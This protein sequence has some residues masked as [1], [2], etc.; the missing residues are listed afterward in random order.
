MNVQKH[1]NYYQSLLLRGAR[2]AS[3]LKMVPGAPKAKGRMWQADALLHIPD[4]T[5]VL[6]ANFHGGLAETTE[7]A[8]AHLNI[9]KVIAH[10]VDPVLELTRASYVLVMLADGIYTVWKYDAAIAKRMRE[11]CSYNT[12]LY[13]GI[14]TEEEMSEIKSLG[15]T[16]IL[17]W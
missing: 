11:L 9:L 17:K 4:F 3:H 13:V 1:P 2:V 6:S 8:E 7:V 16:P 15:Y 14:P 5:V 12:N 10:N